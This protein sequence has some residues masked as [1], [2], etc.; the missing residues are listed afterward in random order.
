[1]GSIMGITGF[2]HA[3]AQTNEKISPDFM[4]FA[5]NLVIDRNKLGKP[6]KGKIFAVIQHHA[7]DIPLLTPGIVF[8]LLNVEYT[9]YLNRLTNKDKS[10]EGTVEQDVISTIC[11]FEI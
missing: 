3:H 10:Y 1:M 11:Y 2:P 4:R 7:D 9:G 6:H 8:K 5:E